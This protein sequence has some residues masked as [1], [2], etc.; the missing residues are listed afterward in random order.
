LSHRGRDGDPLAAFDYFTLAIGRYLDSCN[1]TM[2]R[3]PLVVLADLSDRLGRH[4]PA[5]II[6]RFAFDPLTAATYT[7]I[8][9]VIAHLREVL[10]DQTNRWHRKVPR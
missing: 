5:A 1:T 4:E 8:N 2:M 7:R 3:I 9:T 6:A 10:G